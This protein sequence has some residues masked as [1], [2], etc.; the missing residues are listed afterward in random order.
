M[1]RGGSLDDLIDKVIAQRVECLIDTSTVIED[2]EDHICEVGGKYMCRPK[3]GSRKPLG[4]VVTTRPITELINRIWTW[5]D[6]KVYPAKVREYVS[7][8]EASRR[9]DIC[10]RCKQS[11]RWY[12]DCGPC[13]SKLER[14]LF[15]A[16]AGKLTES[17]SQLERKGC[18]ALGFCHKTAVHLDMKEM[19]IIPD[20]KD[21]PPECWVR[22][23]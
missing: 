5:L 19:E 6:E 23:L 15:C 9:A 17:D 4:A 11:V 8:K 13:N 12:V 18:R 10:R 21:A 7:Q 14:A 2:I 20:A 3:R 1:V 22:K 16:R